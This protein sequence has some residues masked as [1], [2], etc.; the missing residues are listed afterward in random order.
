MNNRPDKRP[1]AV[2]LVAVPEASAAVIYGMH[3]VFAA[4]GTVWDALT[5]QQTEARK[6]V[7]R[8][9][10]RS[11]RPFRSRLGVPLSPDCSY[12][13]SWRADIVIVPDL[14]LSSDGTMEFDRSAINWIGEQFQNG[15][16]VCSVCTGAMMLA[17]AGLL[18]DIEAT[19]HWSIVNSLAAQYPKVRLHP[20]R[21]LSPAGPGHRIIT[22]GG[23]ASWADLVLYLVARFAGADE[24]R[25]IAKVFVLGDRRDG[26]LPFASVA[27]PR[28][29]DDSIIAD[30]QE[31]IATHYEEP[32]PVAR[33]TERSG[34]A[35]RTFA[36]RFK[37]ATGYSAIEYVQTLRVEEAKQMLE[38]SDTMVEDIALSVGYDDPGS[39]RRL[40]K[41]LTGITPRKYRQ[42]FRM[43]H[44]GAAGH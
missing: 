40:F 31:W 35:P 33:M 3:E 32:N 27:R 9:V 17:E 43:L 23:S 5:G 7:P 42:R 28:Q 22:S 34:L 14:E 26:Q 2:H 13:D 15:A 4:V 44:V 19:T 8:I 29:H 20:E 18:D 30:C 10:G 12:G 6:M 16:I 36:R 11:V 37:L 24:A 25:R 21:I 38:A 39:F 1:V 41:R